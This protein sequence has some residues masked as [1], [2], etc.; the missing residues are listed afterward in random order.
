MEGYMMSSRDKSRFSF[1]RRVT[2]RLFSDNNKVNTC[3]FEPMNIVLHRHLVDLV[4]AFSYKSMNVPGRLVPCWLVPCKLIVYRRETR[5]CRYLHGLATLPRGPPAVH[6]FFMSVAVSALLGDLLG[7][8]RFA[9]RDFLLVLTI[10]PRIF[11]SVFIEYHLLLGI[12]YRVNL[13]GACF[14]VSINCFRNC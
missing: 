12:S 3:K 5:H 11:L 7:V 9:E 2:G 8:S 6:C 10:Y 1:R 4:T 14:Y 13:H